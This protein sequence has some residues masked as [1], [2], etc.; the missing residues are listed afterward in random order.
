MRLLVASIVLAS[1]ASADDT[2]PP[3]ISEVR[4]SAKGNKVTVEARITDETGVLSA[5]CHYRSAGRTGDTPM[6]KDE[7]S[8][9]FRATFT[10]G[11]ATEYWIEAT[12]LLGNGPAAHGTSAKPIA[13]ATGV[14]TAR[15][16]Q[17]HH[18]SAPA[19]A[20]PAPAEP[21]KAVARASPSAVERERA[22]RPVPGTEDGAKTPGAEA[23]RPDGAATTP[24]ASMEKA[25]STPQETAVA[26]AE[27]TPRAQTTALRAPYSFTDLPPYRVPPGRPIILRAQVVPAG[28]GQPPDRVALL[29]RGSD[30]RDQLTEMAPDP[31]GGWG[32]YKAQLPAQEDGALFFQIFACDA[33]GI[34]CAVDTGSKRKWHATIVARNPGAPQPGA[35]DAVSSKAPET[36]PQ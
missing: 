13:V 14:A 8:D 5:T 18:R 22:A 1:A 17:E 2:R 16:Q 29:W 15:P 34:R 9:V 28:D 35:L 23:A 11:T 20:R 31:T 33:Q 26:A 4:A 24:S 7:F 36:L 32:G 10:G 25:A 19:R 3:R 6:V 21:P 27:A 30:S 12:D